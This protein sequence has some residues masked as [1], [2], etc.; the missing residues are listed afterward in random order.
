RPKM[1]DL[2]GREA[3]GAILSWLSADDVARVAPLVRAHGADKLLACRL[4]V[5]PTADPDQARLLARRA[6]AAYLNVPV[7]RA[8]QE[9]LGRAPEFQGMWDAWARGER[10][11]ALIELPDELVDQL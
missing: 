11:Q 10:A 6:I 8:F 3:D 1:L 2:A 4:V 7:Y 9:W 5:C